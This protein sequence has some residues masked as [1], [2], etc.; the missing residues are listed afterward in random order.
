LL[1]FKRSSFFIAADLQ[2]G[3]FSLKNRPQLFGQYILFALARLLWLLVSTTERLGSGL[4][5][6]SWYNIPKRR[7]IPIPNN[8]AMYQIATKYEKWL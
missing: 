6:F 2:F 4:P 8:R 5:D 3:N 7:K 1:S